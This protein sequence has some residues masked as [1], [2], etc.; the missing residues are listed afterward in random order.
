MRGGKGLL[1][2][3]Q[4]QWASVASELAFCIALKLNFHRERLPF[5]FTSAPA[6]MLNRRSLPSTFLAACRAAQ[7][8]TGCIR[9]PSD[10]QRGQCHWH[11]MQAAFA[12]HP[13]PTDLA[14]ELLVADPS[15]RQ[16]DVIR[17]IWKAARD[18]GDR[19]QVGLHLGSSRWGNQNGEMGSMH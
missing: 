17:A 6:R 13:P 2:P 12:D 15:W 18:S 10:D 1:L 3:I 16:R 11:P 4:S 19:R 5:G 14:L 9:A 8:V 7:S